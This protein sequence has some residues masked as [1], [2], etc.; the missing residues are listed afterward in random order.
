MKHFLYKPASKKLFF[1]SVNLI[2]WLIGIGRVFDFGVF[3]FG[4]KLATGIL[5]ERGTG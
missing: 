4:I 5:A 2:R 1:V 3:G